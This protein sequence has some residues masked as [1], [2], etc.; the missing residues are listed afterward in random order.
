M[1]EKKRELI[2]NLIA[3]GYIKRKEVA[4]AMMKVPRELFVPEELR[5]M[6]YEDTPLPIGAGQTISAPHMVAYMVEAAELRRGDKV[7]EVGTG[8]G[9]HAAVMA[10]LVG[11]EGHVYTIERIPELAERARER[12]K[13]LGYN[14]VT[15]LVGDGSKGYPPAAPYDKIIVTAAAKRVPE[16]LLKQLK[17]GGIMVI[18]VEEEPGYQVLYKIIK[19]PEGYVIKKLLPVAFVPLI[20]EE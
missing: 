19:T 15:V 4:E 20:E 10:E 14:N 17:V 6:A 18:P 1:E 7:L 11:P 16:A 5:H 3:E 8:S 13:A 9:Y 2:R 12:L